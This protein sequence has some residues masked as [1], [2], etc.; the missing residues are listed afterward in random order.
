MAMTRLSPLHTLAVLA[1]IASALA[2]SSC[3]LPIE[4]AIR[5]VRHEGPISYTGYEV[6]KALDPR[7]RALP[8]NAPLA[9]YRVGVLGFGRTLTAE[10]VYGVPGFVR[11]PYAYPPRLVDVGGATPGSVIICPW[12]MKPF[13]VPPY[14]VYVSTA[15]THY[16]SPAIGDKEVHVTY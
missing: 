14:L 5:K 7:S 13:V 4:D 9:P 12:T 3:A 16:R 15:D 8:Q 1:A 2:L 10:W 6:G 11:S